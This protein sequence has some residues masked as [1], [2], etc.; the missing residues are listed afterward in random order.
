MIKDFFK[1][2]IF[3][4]KIFL[5]SQ[6]NFCFSQSCLTVKIFFREINTTQQE[7]LLD[8]V[9]EIIRFGLFVNLYNRPFFTK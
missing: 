4:E 6:R 2:V 7:E 9:R 3:C 1:T 5:K 8:Y